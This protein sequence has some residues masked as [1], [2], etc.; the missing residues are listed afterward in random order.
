MGIIGARLAE[1]SAGSLAMNGNCWGGHGQECASFARVW[2]ITSAAVK[3]ESDILCTSSNAVRVVNSIPADRPVLFL[4]DRNLGNYVRKQTGREN[5]KIWQGSCIV[6][7]T[8]PVRRLLARQQILCLARQL[9]R[10][11]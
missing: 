10:P 11:P 7:A 4:P 5:M 1:P 8:F 6:H 2:S 9:M 3:A